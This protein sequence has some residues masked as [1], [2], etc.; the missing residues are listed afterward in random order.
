MV[1]LAKGL[2]MDVL[3]TYK[4][5]ICKSVGTVKTWALFKTL[6]VQT[7]SIKEENH[8]DHSISAL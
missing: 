8:K 1:Y 5:G 7:I 6:S 2:D 3:I 4:W